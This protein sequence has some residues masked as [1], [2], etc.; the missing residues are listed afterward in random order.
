[1]RDMPESPIE[2]IEPPHPEPGGQDAGEL[3]VAAV[4][5]EGASEA[6]EKSRIVLAQAPADSYAHSSPKDRTST[7]L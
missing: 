6:G 2:P 5:A 7:R 4:K 3:V 1:M